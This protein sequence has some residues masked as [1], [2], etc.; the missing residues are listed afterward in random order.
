MLGCLV[1]ELR[2]LDAAVVQVTLHPVDGQAFPKH[3]CRPPVVE[4]VGVKYGRLALS[5]FIVPP[6][7][8]YFL[9][10]PST[11]SPDCSVSIMSYWL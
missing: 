8:H 5:R 7:S 11:D 10:I 9:S 2:G 6:D 3:L 1:I 4:I